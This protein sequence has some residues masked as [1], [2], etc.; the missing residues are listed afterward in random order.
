MALIWLAIACAA[1]ALG[2]GRWCTP[3]HACTWRAEHDDVA[4]TTSA[5]AT[6]QLLVRTRASLQPRSGGPRRDR[7]VTESALATADRQVGRERPNRRRSVPLAL[8]ASQGDTVCSPTSALMG[9]SR[10]R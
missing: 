1:A 10:V 4:T 5:I 2:T 9:A 6:I 7:T 8:S 3:N